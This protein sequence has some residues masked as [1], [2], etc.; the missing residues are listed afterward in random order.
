MIRIMGTVLLVVLVSVPLVH[1][2]E[3]VDINTASEAELMKL[4]GIGHVI[5]KR[6]IEYREAQGGFKSIDELTNVKW[7]GK[8]RF[9]MIRDLVT[10]GEKKE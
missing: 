8:K 9:E 1:G 2:A 6:I 7:I 4:P 10:V 3:K 5:A